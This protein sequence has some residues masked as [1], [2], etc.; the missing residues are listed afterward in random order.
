MVTCSCVTGSGLD[1]IRET[2]D[3]RRRRLESTGELELRRS[4]QSLKWMWSLVDDGLRAAVRGHPGVTAK[5]EELER[6]V[7]DGVTT[8]AAAAEAILDA[9][10][11]PSR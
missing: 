3:E 8:A 1:A 10:R 11:T 2:I 4:R 9:F 5:L 7:V 6:D